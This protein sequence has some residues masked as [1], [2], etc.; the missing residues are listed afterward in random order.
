MCQVSLHWDNTPFLIIVIIQ[1]LTVQHVHRITAG[2][3]S[4]IILEFLIRNTNLFLLIQQNI[5]EKSFKN[6]VSLQ[7]Q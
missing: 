4:E 7:R 1:L 2:I 6:V 3:R 5:I